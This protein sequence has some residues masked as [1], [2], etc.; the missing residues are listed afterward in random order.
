MAEQNLSKYTYKDIFSLSVVQFEKA[1]VFNK[2]EQI[3]AYSIYWI[4]EGKG[5]YNIDF[6]SY[7]FEDNVLVFLSPGQVFSV[8]S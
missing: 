4:I 8:E 6:E 2:P 3:D 5:R 1:C 7:T